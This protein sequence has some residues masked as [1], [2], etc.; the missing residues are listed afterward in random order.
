MRL[1]VLVVLACTL[2]YSGVAFGKTP[3]GKIVANGID[4]MF[5]DAHAP[6]YLPRYSR[7]E[8][9]TLIRNATTTEDFEL[10]ADYFDFKALEFRAKSKDQE[11]ELQR[12]IALPY[13]SRSYPAQFDSAR[14][15]LRSY[16]EQAQKCSARA[17]AYRQRVNH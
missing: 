1:R 6:D 5:V 11:K 8:L 9:K 14:A 12:L 7:S 15:L 2:P 4:T 10:L 17:A 16:I 3:Q 13:H